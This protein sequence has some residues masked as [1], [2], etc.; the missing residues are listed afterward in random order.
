MI[1]GEGVRRFLF[2]VN[3]FEIV[4]TVILLKRFFPKNG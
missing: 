1:E 3:E 4:W 2:H